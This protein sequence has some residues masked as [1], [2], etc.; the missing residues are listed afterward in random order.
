M[1][2]EYPELLFELYNN[3]IS[4]LKSRF[5]HHTQGVYKTYTMFHSPRKVLN[6]TYSCQETI[7]QRE[8]FCIKWIVGKAYKNG[9]GSLIRPHFQTTAVVAWLF[10][11]LVLAAFKLH[12]CI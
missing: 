1:L 6:C 4:L 11:D 5:E 3:L 12:V 7:F 9:G 2:P 10:S 8:L